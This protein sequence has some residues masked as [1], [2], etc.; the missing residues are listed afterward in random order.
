MSNTMVRAPRRVSRGKVG[1]SLLAC[2]LAA[3]GAGKI[4]AS[5]SS[6]PHSS[7][8]GVAP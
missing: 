7:F 5:P 4:A 6:A 3:L 2:V 8:L 1:L